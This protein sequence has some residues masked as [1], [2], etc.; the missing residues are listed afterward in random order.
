MSMSQTLATSWRVVALSAVVGLGGL[1]VAPAQAGRV[2]TT[3][4]SGGGPG[5]SQPQDRLFNCA[6]SNLPVAALQTGQFDCR[7]A[8]G[9]SYT[10][11]TYFNVIEELVSG[12]FGAVGQWTSKDESSNVGFTNTILQFGAGLQGQSGDFVLVFSG[13]WLSDPFALNNTGRSGWS[14]YYLLED[15][16]IDVGPFNILPY[17]LRG[18]DQASPYVTR[19]LVVEAVSFYRINRVPEPD[20]LALVGLALAALL[21]VTGRRS[22]VR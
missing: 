15:I 22:R 6:R 17:S 21:L 2:I 1:A 5:I 3:S 7:G 11:A 8:L 19:G 16:G 9:H 20:G 14:S 18:T 4:D 10:K 12:D 13:T